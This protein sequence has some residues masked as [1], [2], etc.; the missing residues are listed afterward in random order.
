MIDNESWT[1]PNNIRRNSVSCGLPSLIQRSQALL[2]NNIFDVVDLLDTGGCEYERV[3]VS[4]EHVILYPDPH[5]AELLRNWSV[6]WS[7][8]DSWKI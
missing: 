5:S 1:I 8:V 2:A 4:D 7:D 3:S 6:V